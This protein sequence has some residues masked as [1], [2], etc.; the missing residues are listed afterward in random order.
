M[1]REYVTRMKFIAEHG[2]DELDFEDE[3]NIASTHGNDQTAQ[4]L[5]DASIHSRLDIF[6]GGTAVNTITV[7][8][9][10]IKVFLGIISS[11]AVRIEMR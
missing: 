3:A 6:A 2:S 5:R 11:L 7:H 10:Q 9:Y 4:Y 1:A 8:L